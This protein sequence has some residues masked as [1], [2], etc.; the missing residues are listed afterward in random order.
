MA[1]EVVISELAEMNYESILTYL[2]SDWGI[3]VAN[4]FVER[5]EEVCSHLEN[6]TSIYPFANKVKQIQ[7]CI[8]T[9]QN[10]LYFKESENVVEILM[11]FDTR[12]D[13]K[14]L[15]KLL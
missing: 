10:A 13:P 8:L 4:N 14:K 6:N 15:L 2:Y 5:F 11:I 1:K 3:N 9:E 12:Q 7:R